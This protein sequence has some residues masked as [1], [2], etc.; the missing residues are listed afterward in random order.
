MKGQHLGAHGGDRGA[1]VEDLLQ[2]GGPRERHGDPHERE[3]RV[4]EAN[5]IMN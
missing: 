1:R 2:R 5:E 3:G 4:K